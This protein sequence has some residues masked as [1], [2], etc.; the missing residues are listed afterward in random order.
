MLT[1]GEDLSSCYLLHYAIDDGLYDIAKFLIE[2]GKIP[3][4]T[5]DTSGWTALHLAAG[6]NNIDM[7]KLLIEKGADINPRVREIQ[8][9]S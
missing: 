1:S 5:V 6:H 8:F 2:K 4:N 3:L 7:V 9:A